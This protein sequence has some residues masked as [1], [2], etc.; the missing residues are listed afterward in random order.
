MIFRIPY[1]NSEHKNMVQ[2]SNQK[3][4]SIVEMLVVLTIVIILSAMAVM[5]YSSPKKYVADDQAKIIIDVLFH[6]M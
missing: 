1:P 4:Y 6:W 2:L 3:G 5:T